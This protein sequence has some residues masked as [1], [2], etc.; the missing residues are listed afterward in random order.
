MDGTGH[1]TPLFSGPS[2]ARHVGVKDWIGDFL[3][4]T[5]GTQTAD[6]F[7]LWSAI[8]CLGAAMERRVWGI[9]SRD[10]I[11]PNCFTILVGPPGVGKSM[12][13]K[14]VDKLWQGTGRL[15]ISPTSVT[16]AGLADCFT[17]AAKNIVT[18]DGEILEYSSVLVASSEFGNFV[19]TADLEFLSVL[20][21][22]FDNP[23]RYNEGRRTVE[24]AADVTNPQ[25]SIL[26]ATTPSFLG[27]LLTDSA[28]AQ[29][30]P[31]RLLM[32]Y[33]H[34]SPTADLFGDQDPR[35][36]LWQ[37]LQDR[38]T[39][40]A[41][42]EFAG[43]VAWAPD[44]VE[45]LVPW[46]QSGLG[47]LPSHP[48]LE[49]YSSRRIVHVL[50]LAI[51]SSVSRGSNFVVEA[52]DLRRAKRWLLENESTMG[53]I[54]EKVSNK[55]DVQLMKELHNK[56]WIVYQLNKK[57]VPSSEILRFLGERAPIVKVAPLFHQAIGSG[58]F[59][60]VEGLPLYV[61]NP[62]H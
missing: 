61:P 32:V 23:E 14:P 26:A 41:S 38:L 18:R 3:T 48:R 44:F 62:L 50:K 9:S 1:P 19:P 30:F 22:T 27:D 15:H 46:H 21:H 57:P 10:R 25:L 55:S 16:R 42:D 43:Q 52:C 40:I 20:N 59:T 33:A 47:P 4:Y 29:G 49:H 13:I 5:E 54:F 34:D 8:S 53:A 45:E 6:S 11:Y 12:A 31:S 28:W 39:M 58:M 35:T 36:A 17:A 56:F 7:R 2:T 37:S 24:N 60:K 51:I